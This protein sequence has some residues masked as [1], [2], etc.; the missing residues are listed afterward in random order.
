MAYF[1]S[2]LF[3]ILQNFV[4]LYQ[5]NLRITYQG[6]S[7]HEVRAYGILRRIQIELVLLTEVIELVLLTA[8]KESASVPRGRAA[9]KA[10]PICAGTSALKTHLNT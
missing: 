9:K 8:V 6:G 4:P 1:W 3:S 5:F 10:S 7:P 2:E